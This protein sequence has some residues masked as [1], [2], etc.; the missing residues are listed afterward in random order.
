M[1]V[2][3]DNRKKYPRIL[4]ILQWHSSRHWLL[5]FIL[6]VAG[7]L[8]IGYFWISAR[9]IGLP[10]NPLSMYQWC[11]CVKLELVW[12]RVKLPNNLLT[13]AY[14]LHSILAISARSGFLR[15][16]VETL[17]KRVMAF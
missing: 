4:M 7:C 15:K 6:W 16:K 3:S 2:V 5:H 17:R 14:S 10:L 13:R 11:F 9:R 1:V 12:I 8:A